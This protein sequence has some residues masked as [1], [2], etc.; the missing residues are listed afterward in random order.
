MNTNQLWQTFLETGAPE[1][2]VLYNEAKKLE[3]VD[4]SDDQGPGIACNQL[5]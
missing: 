1:V 4:V 2:Y 5:Q 3:A